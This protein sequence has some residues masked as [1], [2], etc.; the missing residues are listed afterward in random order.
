MA[1]PQTEDLQTFLAVVDED[2]MNGAARALGVPKSTISRRLNR[3]E[4]LL[5][6]RLFLRNRQRLTLSES[7]A[8]LIE[9]SRQA[10]DQL[11]TIGEAA[12]EAR[13][14]PVG[15]LR[16]SIPLDLSTHTELWL[17]FVEKYPKVALEA[18]F[19]NTYVDVI[20]QRLDLALRAGRGDDESLVARAVGHYPLVA[21][22]HPKHIEQHGP[23]ETPADLR[24]RDCVLMS[25]MRPRPHQPDHPQLP[26]RHLVFDS[27]HLVQQAALRGLGIAILPKELIDDDLQNGNLVS[28][29]DAY[30]PLNVPLFAVY[31]DR[32]HLKASVTAFMEHVEAYFS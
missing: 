2:G 1:L 26:H 15:P 19:T 24:R 9:Q 25:A 27:L 11:Q 13:A 23:I 10:L 28:V 3:L 18:E 17:S 16:V 5:G 20:R 8:A 31:P 29:L 4:E 12:S 30:N 7:G 21:V 22:A 6:V 14:E 32:A